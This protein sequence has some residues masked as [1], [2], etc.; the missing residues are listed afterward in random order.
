MI[1]EL[2]YTF[3]A[4]GLKPGSTGFCTVAAT[5]GLPD[6]IA[7]KLELLSSYKELYAPRDPQFAHNP[8]LW[9]HVRL[10]LHTRCYDVLSRVAATS[11]DP[12]GR[13]NRLAHHL[14][15]E[16]MCLPP[17]GPA[18]L[19][20]QPGL[21]QE[22]WDGRVQSLPARAG[23]PRGEQP[24]WGC[25]RWEALTGDPAWA[26]VLAEDFLKEPWRPVYLLY[27]R[28]TDV[29][30]LLAEALALMPAERRWEVTFSTFYRSGPAAISCAW[31]G[32]PLEAPEAADLHRRQGIRILELTPSLGPAPANGLSGTLRKWRGVMTAPGPSPQP[33]A[34]ADPP[35]APEPPALPPPLCR[36]TTATAHE[37]DTGVERLDDAVAPPPIPPTRSKALPFLTGSVAGMVLAAVI[38]ALLW[39][40]A[41]PRV[42]PPPAVPEEVKSVPKQVEKLKEQLRQQEA[43]H[44]R[45]LEDVRDQLAA[46]NRDMHR[47]NQDLGKVRQAA[48]DKDK[49]LKAAKDSAARSQA[50]ATAARKERDARDQLLRDVLG[51]K[52][53]DPIPGVGGIDSKARAALRERWDETA[54]AQEAYKDSLEK[55]KKELEQ[56]RRSLEDWK[57]LTARHNTKDKLALYLKGFPG[58]LVAFNKESEAWAKACPAMLQKLDTILA[59][60]RAASLARLAGEQKADVEEFR[61]EWQ[62]LEATIREAVPK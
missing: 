26:G 49:E 24:P 14:V 4:R 1:W 44:D 60:T 25:R 7:T 46:A 5:P 56:R 53:A 19:L 8:V 51:L 33:V 11:P 47:L 3:A 36:P 20:S 6:A 31:R 30:G 57:K 29:L 21:V 43:Q 52:P 17:E 62:K 27:P 42:S 39:R 34:V 22:A 12:S 23:L 37:P 18:W 40:L 58:R 41:P 54:R 10:T 32:L 16:G 15:L 38:A 61:A 50:E 28:G 48:A 35:A 9:S 13:S 59:S 45:E 2:Y 55:F